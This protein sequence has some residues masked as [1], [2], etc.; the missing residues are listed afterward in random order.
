MTSLSRPRSS[1]TPKKFGYPTTTAAV[2]RF[3][4]CGQPLGIEPTVFSERCFDQVDATDTA[5][6]GARHLTVLR[7]KRA[8][9][10][11][12]LPPALQPQRHEH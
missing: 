2:P 4:F 5:Q 9:E 7:V 11:H 10:D 8:R 1:I 6:V 12:A 3:V